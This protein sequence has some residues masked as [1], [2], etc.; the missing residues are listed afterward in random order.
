MSSNLLETSGI[1]SRVCPHCD[2]TTPWGYAEKPVIREVPGGEKPAV[3]EAKAQ[4][5]VGGIEQR[6]HY[7]VSLQLPVLVRDYDGGVEITKSE[8]VSQGGLCIS[9]EKSYLFGQGLLVIC[10]YDPKTSQIETHARV[11]RRQ[12]I[13]G[14]S[15]KVYGLRY[16]PQTG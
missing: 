9:S 13:E 12:E 7:R 14:V 10:P 16:T 6:R 2:V 15:R 4:A 3:E 11:V 1:I 8:N 5:F